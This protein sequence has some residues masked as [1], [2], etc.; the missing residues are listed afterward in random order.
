MQDNYWTR[1][2]VTRRA[3][4]RGGLTGIAGLAGAALIGCGGDDDD[5]AA[6]PSTPAAAAPTATTTGAA[7]P[8]AA[9]VTVDF[10]RGGI[11][12][13]GTPNL[14]AGVDP[15]FSGAGYHK[16]KTLFDTLMDF[17]ESGNVG[18]RDD[19]LA[20]SA[21][22]VDDTTIVLG[23]RQGVKFHDGTD[24]NA[25]AVVYTMERLL[26]PNPPTGTPHKGEVLHTNKVEAIDEFTVRWTLNQPDS[27]I[28]T[29]FTN[30]STE[31]LSPTHYG[32][33]DWEDTQFDPV[34]TGRYMFLDYSQDAFFKFQ[35]FPDYFHK[36]ADGGPAGMVDE[37]HELDMPDAV[38]RAS[39]LINGDIE[40]LDE[41]PKN[42][43]DIL[44]ST[45]AVHGEK[46]DGF[47][48]RNAYINHG[49]PPLD[50][51]DVRRALAWA[52]DAD[53]YNEVYEGGTGVP[54]TSYL[55]RLHWAHID[56]PEHPKFD[57]EKAKEFMAASGV[58]ESER[59][60]RI[61]GNT[62]AFQFVQ[63]AWEKIGF[64][65]EH[66]ADRTGRYSR[67]RGDENP[68]I[69]MSVGSRITSRPD[70]GWQ[71]NVMLRS[72]A[73][74]N[75][76]W[77]P[78]ANIDELSDKGLA[79]YDIDERKAVYEEIQHIHA[80]Q[81]FAHILKVDIPFWVHAR[82]EVGGIRHYGTGRG[83]YRYLHFK[84]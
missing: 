16:A 13:L 69:H 37:I 50:N 76:G 36:L 83:D 40:A 3:V 26:Q 84:A 2:R 64:Q 78:T 18:I 54:A 41:S 33:K 72:D 31:M 47:A 21:E 80:D 30:H 27:G 17:D 34:G 29:A 53:G 6:A 42:Q 20:V 12:R 22:L 56:V 8:T 68:D 14:S 19:A 55:S 5:D 57:V 67:A 4:L 60:L 11:I 77:A 52:W 10:K 48:I 35:V 71:T 63:A 82:A 24:F 7:A 49:L 15:T 81:L 79:T 66:I 25:E 74:Y 44:N 23:L 73:I 38:A 1:R 28:F 59:K 46:A 75:I 45:N 43:L 61:T 39:A 9:P 51:V 62:V 70:P 58:P 32:D 65:S